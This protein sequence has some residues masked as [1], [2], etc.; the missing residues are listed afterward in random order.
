LSSLYMLDIS[1]LS[2]WSGNSCTDRLD[3]DVICFLLKYV[4]EIR[5]CLGKT[6]QDKMRL[7]NF[8]L[9]LQYLPYPILVRQWLLS[10]INKNKIE[11]CMSWHLSFYC[12]HHPVQRI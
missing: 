6:T 2:D 11:S 3:R 9:E 12:I 4:L 1:P 10:H 8:P 5:A 7:N